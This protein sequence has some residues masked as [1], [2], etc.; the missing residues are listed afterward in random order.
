MMLGFLWQAAKGNRLRPWRSRY[1]LWRIETYWG[2]HAD[3]VTPRQFRGFVWEH[4]REL[5]RFLRWAARMR[6]QPAQ[7]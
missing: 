3:A 6:Q 7:S 5:L 4:R 1:L 2:C